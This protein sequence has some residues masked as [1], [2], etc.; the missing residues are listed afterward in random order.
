MDLS[1]NA[2]YSFNRTVYHT[3]PSIQTTVNNLQVGLSGRNYFLHRFVLAYDASH[4]FNNG[5]GGTFSSNPTMINAS[6][7]RWFLKKRT[8]SI[9]LQAYNMLNQRMAIGR[10]VSGNTI[11]DNQ[12]VGVGRYFMLTGNLRFN[13]F[14]GAGKDRRYPD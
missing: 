2:N 8:V 12:G 6:L 5:Y 3:G 9:K 10:T 4:V 13:K 1:L 7:E 14:P 11:T